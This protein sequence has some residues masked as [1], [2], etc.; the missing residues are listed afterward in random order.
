VSIWSNDGWDVA[1]AIWG[2]VEVW[3]YRLKAS[4]W[5]AALL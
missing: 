1:S 5:A 4:C 2:G 3:R